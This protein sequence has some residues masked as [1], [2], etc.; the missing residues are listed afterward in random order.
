MSVRRFPKSARL[1]RKARR[2]IPGGVSSLVRASNKPHPLY[3]RS[4]SGSRL[5][6]VDGN[7]YLDYALGWGPLI[8]GHS[9]PGVMRAVERQLKKFQTLGAQHELE[10]AV[11]EKIC[12]MV[13]C[14][15][16]VAFS[17]TGSEAVQLALRL[18]RAHTG[19][20]KL[21]KF[22]GHYHGSP[23][24]VLISFHPP[25]IAHPPTEPV[26]GSEG[27]SSTALDDVCVLPWNDLPALE[28]ALKEHHRDIA[29]II[30]EPILCNT[31]CLVP[32]PGYL[33]G[34]RRLATRYGVVLVFDEIITGFRVAPGGAQ[35]LYGVR[36]DLA[37]FGKAVAAGFPLSVVAGKREIMDWIAEGRVVH[38]GS[39]NGNPIALAAADAAL[40]F[41]AA[42]R[43][44]QLRRIRRSGE[45]LMKGI[46]QQAERAG[47]PLLING[48]G[49]AFHLSFTRRAEMR[50]YRE[51]LDCDLEARDQFIVAMLHAG[52]Y[53]LP[54]GRWYVSTAHSK[55]DV[56]K[57]LKAV[58]DVF[59][60][61]RNDRN[62]SRRR[63][64]S[65]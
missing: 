12:R 7:K 11:A 1:F 31:S 13:P 54:E 34:M 57:T 51:S 60:R 61:F 26:P 56:E 25:G 55:A 40:K 29:A 38:A 21:L 10:I 17:S 44:V 4:A 20:R 59:R 2:L 27:Q 30:T 28:A 3:F 9:H 22:E 63:T 35:E 53:L 5:I 6:D 15:E 14:A 52:V 8:L 39:F 33:K 47:I 50:D 49:A 42:N 46:G 19:R 62:V 43:G 32:V 23:D 16:Q 48:V 36:P 24:N 65:T 41:L 18:A 37:T 45:A 64:K 58:G